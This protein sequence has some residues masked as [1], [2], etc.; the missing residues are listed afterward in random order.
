M[1]LVNL[2]VVIALFQYVFF[3]TRVGN[4]RVTYGI[5]APAT[6]GNPVFERYYRVQMNTLELL[7]LLI[8]A[9]W[10]ASTYWSSYFVAAMLGIYVVGRH[11]YYV[12]YVADPARRSMGFLVSFA[13]IAIL[14]LS[15]AGGAIRDII[16]NGL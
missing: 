8:P 15:G 11:M 9:V 12:G 7:I 2:L 1:S 5:K 13:P 6:A 16:R 3:A 4:A 10:M 14:L